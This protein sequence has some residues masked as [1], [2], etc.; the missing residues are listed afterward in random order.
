MAGNILPDENKRFFTMAAE[1][2][3]TY[4]ITEK[5]DRR[6]LEFVPS[7]FYSWMPWKWRNRNFSGSVTGG[8]GFDSSNPVVFLGVSG[9]F[10]RNVSLLGGVAVRQQTELLG[11]YSENQVLMQDLSDDS[12]TE[13]TYKPSW[14]LGVSFRFGKSPFAK[15]KGSE[16]PTMVLDDKKKDDKKEPKQGDDGGSA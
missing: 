15:S 5:E 11:E 12:L 16:T 13:E 14:F 10:N 3:Q 7:V 8:L 6:D 1:D 4:T 2:G 9:T